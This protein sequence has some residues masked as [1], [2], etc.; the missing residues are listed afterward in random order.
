MNPNNG[1]LLLLALGTFLLF[2]GRQVLG[3]RLVTVVTVVILVLSLLQLDRVMLLPLENRFPIPEPLPSPVH[4]VVVLGGAERARLTH[5]R[6]QVVLSD[7]AERLTT[8]VGLSRLYPN[9]KLVYAGGAGGLNEQRFKGADTAKLLFKQLG[10]DSGRVQFELNSRNT[11]ENA[12]NAFELAKPKKGEN[13]VLITSAW[14]LPRAVGVFRN[15]GWSV[16]PYPVDFFTS[17]KMELSLGFAGLSSA[18]SVTWVSREW[19]GLVAYWIMGRTSELF[20]GPE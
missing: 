6:G 3:R 14:H 10:L 15:I 12:Q 2:T 4:G 9:A 20:P 17:G 13:W 1:L 8:F 16:I 7:A 5:A 19:V 11:L 18:S